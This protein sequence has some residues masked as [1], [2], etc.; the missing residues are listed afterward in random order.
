MYLS[1][2]YIRFVRIFGKGIFLLLLL[3]S[4]LGYSQTRKKNSSK[5]NLQQKKAKIEKDI[6]VTN[7]LLEETKKNKKASLRQLVVLN[8]K[9]NKREELISNISTELSKLDQQ[10]FITS[11]QVRRLKNEIKDL[12][13][14]YAKMIYYA[15]KNKNYYNRV[16]FVFAS[17]SFNQA[18]RRVKYF[19]QYSS[20]RKNQAQLIQNTQILLDSKISELGKKKE[21]KLSLLQTHEKEKIQLSQEKEEQ[22]KTIRQ[23]TQKERKL[24]VELKE[25][26]KASR[27]L[28][29]AIENLI[30]EE[31][32]KTR[33]VAKKS[34][35]KSA[36]VTISYTPAEMKLANNFSLNK[37]RLPWPSEKG[38]LSSSFGE[39]EHPILKGI[40]TKNNGITIS[41]NPGAKA[42][43]VFDGVVSSVLTIPNYNHVVILS[44]GE[45][46]TVYTNLVDVYVRRGESVST[47]QS[48]GTV[49]TDPETNKTELH[50]E[51]W[52]GKTTLNPAQWISR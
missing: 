3:I 37:G 9:I 48:L 4:V 43:A 34:G 51:I 13:D 36:P 35:K 23:L 11:S 19:Q 25:K 29:A 15:Y 49:F 14:E 1:A 8:D 7:K 18:Y 24:L 52:K 21:A 16:M 26:E 28:Q 50:F 46:L 27:Q 2:C 45:Y 5:E 38:A 10:I 33:E 40:K 47:K 6:K 30:S 12:K 39:H 32:R 44:H 31:L 22:N 41:T 42:R 20:Y 17:Q